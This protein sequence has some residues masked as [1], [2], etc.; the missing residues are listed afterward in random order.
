LF[1]QIFDAL[2]IEI[3]QVITH[4]VG[5][6]IAV[7]ILKRFAWKPI[8]NLLEE[9][10]QRIKDNFDE[11]ESKHA[12]ADRLNEEYQAK[13]REID[14]EA[15]KR[16]TAAVAEGEKIAARIKE[17]SRNEA[18]DMITKAQADL[19]RDVAKAR[20]ALKGDM[21][22]MALAATEKM[23]MEKL[24]EQKHRDMIGRF[25]DELETQKQQ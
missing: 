25:I 1:E 19:E 6:V 2:R 11:I 21:V 4:L 9:R 15:R 14:A 20:V 16:L 10:R 13:L 12:E 24:D 3:P 8:L 5:F 17:D 23:I 7:L 22:D 18:K